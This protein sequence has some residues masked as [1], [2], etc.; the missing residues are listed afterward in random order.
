ML[1]QPSGMDMNLQGS[2]TWLLLKNESG[3]VL[4][5]VRVEIR[6]ELDESLLL[7]GVAS[8]ALDLTFASAGAG[9]VPAQLASET[10]LEDRYVLLAPP[11]SPYRGRASV[12]LAAAIR[13]GAVGRFQSAVGN[14]HRC[15]TCVGRG[16][17][18]GL[19]A[20]APRAGAARAAR[21]P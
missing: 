16:A 2:N 1:Y 20:P 15:H 17:R 3:T 12:T 13:R 7:D 6:E 9:P 5:D 18:I 10:L 14:C 4:P 19:P 11:G 8:G 21:S